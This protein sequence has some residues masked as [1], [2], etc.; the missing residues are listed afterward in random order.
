MAIT[1]EVETTQTTPPEFR[2][3]Q[4]SVITLVFALCVP[5]AVALTLL[6]MAFTGAF[7][8]GTALY[9]P[10]DL[11]TYG[12]PIVR[13]IHDIAAAAT[14]G[15]LVLAATVLPGQTKRHGE[16]GHSQWKAVRW[17]AIAGI[18]WFVAAVIV[19]ILSGIQISGVPVGDPLF[20]STFRTFLINVALGQ[21][22]V[23]SALC[24]LV[25]VIIALVARRL[26]TVGF[27]AGFALFALL[28]L[29]LSGHAAGSLEHDN[30]V[31]SLAIHLV[32]VT[33]WVGGLAGILVLR[34]TINKGFGT[35]VARYSALA[36]WAFG[37]VAFSGIVNSALRLGTF[38]D[39]LAPYGLLIVAKASILI[40]LGLFGAFQ[41]KRIIPSLRADPMNRRLF[42]RFATAEVVFMALAIGISVGLAKSPP[43]V[44]QAPLTGNFARDG[45]LGFTY[46][47]PVNFARM[48]TTFH[49]DWMWLG[50]IV[51]MA[52]WYVASVIIL[53]RRGDRW[54]IY[55]VIAWL[56]GC[57]VLVW[58]TSGGAFVYGLIHFSSHMVQHMGLMM[59]APPLL[60]LGGPILLALRTLPT[61]HDGSRGIREWMLLLTHSRFLAFLAR[62]AVA[63][64]I[65]AGSLIAFYYSPAFQW[66][67]Q[68]HV[69]HV[70]MMFH[71]LASGYLFFWVFIGV[72][73]GPKR[74]SYPM[75]LITLLA[76]LAFHA[77]FGVALME[78][79]DVLALDWWR[80][81]GQ[82]NVAALLADQ[83]AGGGIAWGA[84]EIPMVLVALGV[85]YRWMKSDERTAKRLDRQADRDGDADLTAYNAR[86]QKMA[87]RE[88]S[89]G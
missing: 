78:S 59:F 39:L 62:P 40:V 57:V 37:A 8:T 55:R 83:H 29:A 26:T 80:A 51:V 47:P 16:V 27:A 73:P 69:G 38:A 48:F 13:T 22:L 1:D 34:R 71:F 58:V 84:S 81:L 60:V 24:I 56:A 32:G 77:F 11:V 43:P 65:F 52:A 76:T 63:G 45:L 10:G 42:L 82:T 44:S 75:L 25:A 23:V 88:E 61:R 19:I 4:L 64:I 46:P 15:L 6:G 33:V 66:A 72:D 14:V 41:R 20:A 35:A 68:D 49:W 3:P 9:N 36:A 67:E 7:S 86:L 85:A 30:A 53:R 79:S 5:A 89:A 50:L 54:P 74:P 2:M 17:A 18:V 31:N 28:P 87:D 12:L 21:S 70:F